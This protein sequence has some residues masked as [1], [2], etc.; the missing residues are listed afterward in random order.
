MWRPAVLGSLLACTSL[1]SHGRGLLD[2]YLYDPDEGECFAEADGVTTH[3]CDWRCRVPVSR[4][5]TV[6]AKAQVWSVQCQKCM[7][8]ACS[9]CVLI[10]SRSPPASD[11]TSCCRDD[12]DSC[13]TYKAVG[14]PTWAPGSNE[15][16]VAK[17]GHLADWAQTHF[18]AQVSVPNWHE[19]MTVDVSFGNCMLWRCEVQP[20]PGV[21]V[22]LLAAGSETSCS[23]RLRASPASALRSVTQQRAANVF[24]FAVL[25]RCKRGASF[26]PYVRRPVASCTLLTPP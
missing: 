17:E 14:Y 4:A 21:P 11:D 6:E 18:G 25:S 5:H 13:P 3:R 10:Y 23:F 15:V 12:K 20:G 2:G 19:G 7:C 24:E 9:D 1:A 8:M 16:E 26:T 22:E